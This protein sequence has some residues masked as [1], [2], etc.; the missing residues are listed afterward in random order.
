M[1]V[2]KGAFSELVAFLSGPFVTKN[3]EL[4]Q[5]HVVY[6]LNREPRQ[7][8]A[9]FDFHRTKSVIAGL[10][11]QLG[12]RAFGDARFA[13][14]VKHQPNLAVFGRVIKLVSDQGDVLARCDQRPAGG[15]I[16]AV[17]DARNHVPH[18]VAVS[19]RI[20]GERLELVVDVIPPSGTQYDQRHENGHGLGTTNHFT[21][22]HRLG[23][24]FGGLSGSGRSGLGR[25]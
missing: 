8:L 20:G 1:G 7:A 22:G 17:V 12:G 19:K 13:F 4:R 10:G 9:A 16:I 25:R 2:A 24:S 23:F 14:A 18:A 11:E 21:K 15:F 6:A 5:R 3:I